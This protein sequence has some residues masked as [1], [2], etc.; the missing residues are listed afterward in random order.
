MGTCYP[1]CEKTLFWNR[2]VTGHDFSRAAKAP[3]NEPALAAAEAQMAEIIPQG[4]K[5][6]VFLM[7][8]RHDLTGCGKT[9]DFG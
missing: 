8:L 1:G 5:P 3:K 6:D 7:S 2:S 9:L 4:L